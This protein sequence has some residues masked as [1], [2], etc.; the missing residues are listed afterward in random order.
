MIGLKNLMK[1]RTC[2]VVAHRLHTVIDAH[3]IVVMHKV[4][5]LKLKVFC[6]HTIGC[7]R[8]ARQT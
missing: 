1:N 7:Y 2:L 5:L 6:K 8:G 3:K 4:L